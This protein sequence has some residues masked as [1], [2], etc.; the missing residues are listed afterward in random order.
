LA[1]KTINHH[2]LYQHHH[3]CFPIV[4]LHPTTHPTP[5]TIQSTPTH[6]TF[7][8]CPTSLSPPPPNHFYTTSRHGQTPRPLLSV[9]PKIQ[10]T[11][12]YLLPLPSHHKHHP[13]Y[14][15]LLTLHSHLSFLA[16]NTFLSPTPIHLVYHSL[17]HILYRFQIFPY[18]I[19]APFTPTTF[20]TLY[21][22]TIHTHHLHPLLPT[23]SFLEPIQ[24]CL[25]STFYIYIIYIPYNT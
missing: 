14:L 4:P 21:I 11:P 8:P 5:I 25:T 7:M 23:T 24:L 13:F 22:N 2:I 18:Y 1:I 17:N 12:P 20:C 3:T 10:Y 9:T 16:P 15:L 6:T 19:C